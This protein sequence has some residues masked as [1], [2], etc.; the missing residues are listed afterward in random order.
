MIVSRAARHRRVR[1]LSRSVGALLVALS[2]GAGPASAGD[3]L[4]GPIFADTAANGRRDVTGLYVFRSPAD[5]NNTV[6]VFTV[7]PFAGNL[8]P[9][10][11]DPALYYDI[12]ISTTA[13]RVP[14][15]DITFRVSFGPP[16]ANNVQDVVLRGLPVAR[17]APTGILAQGKTGTNLPV[18][19]GGLFRA[20]VQ[21]DPFFFDL[22]A[23]NDLVNDGVG[24]FPRPIGQARN[25]F[26]PNVNTLAIVLEIPSAVLGPT[27]AV[28]GVWARTELGSVQQDRTAFPA[29]NHLLIPP[30]PRNSPTAVERRNAFNAGHPARDRQTFRS[31][32]VGVAQSFY[33]RAAFDATVIANTFLPDILLFA[34]GNPAGFGTF[35][36]DPFKPGLGT[37]LGNGRRLRDDVMDILINFL[38][39][40]AIVTDNV[41]DDN[42]TRITDGD[43]GTTAAFPYI[44][45]ANVF[46]PGA[47]LVGPGGVSQPGNSGPN[48]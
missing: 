12:R 7:A 26:G 24:A 15:D 8:I 28:I 23:F 22:G 25:F 4:D 9:A 11:F 2:L 13:V 5:A 32:V 21:D 41:P 37:V 14:T 46:A 43:M 38:T 27:G 48:P 47:N 3:H 33:G 30:L 17:F 20:G 34:L 36:S 39:N 35:I 31:E 18:L 42:G 1:G 40:G 19:G 45:A 29:I 6:F 10:P 16:D 44:G